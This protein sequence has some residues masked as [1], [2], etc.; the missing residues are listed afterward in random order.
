MCVSIDSLATLIPSS[1]CALCKFQSLRKSHPDSEKGNKMTAL[2]FDSETELYTL[3]KVDDIDGALFLIPHHHHSLWP[4]HIL[5]IPPL[6]R[7]Y[8]LT[9]TSPSVEKAIFHDF[10]PSSAP[11][12]KVHLSGGKKE[13]GNGRVLAEVLV[14]E[15]Q[16]GKGKRGTVSQ[17]SL[18]NGFY[19][20]P[21]SSRTGTRTTLVSEKDAAAVRV[22]GGQQSPVELSAHGSMKRQH[23]RQQ[24]HQGTRTKPIE[25]FADGIPPVPVPVPVPVPPLPSKSLPRTPAPVLLNP[26][27]RSP[28]MRKN[29]P[30]LALPP[31]S[32]PHSRIAVSEMDMKEGKERSYFSYRS[33]SSVGRESIPIAYMP[34]H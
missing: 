21:S 14:D 7:N 4:S 34:S 33:R 3:E 24:R 10:L 27:P 17:S 13:S 12:I 23:H 15:A 19:I 8:L 28:N 5:V 26:R 31:L 2:V 9:S 16:K 6:P 25:L 11:S 29:S 32:L 30:L 1:C 20:L 22:Q 18:V